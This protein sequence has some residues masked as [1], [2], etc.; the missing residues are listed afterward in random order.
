M[1]V[2]VSRETEEIGKEV[3]SVRR[4]LAKKDEEY[5]SLTRRITGEREVNTTCVY[6]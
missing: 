4:K 6:Q 3:E 5:N 2:E 1:S